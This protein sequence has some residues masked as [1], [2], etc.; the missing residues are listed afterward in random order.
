MKVSRLPQNPIITP[1]MDARMGDNINGPSLIEAPAWLPNRLGRYYLYFGHH[2]G[3]YIR[4]AVADDIAGPWR[5]HEPGVLPLANSG[6]AGHIASPDVHVDE[7]NQQI[8][9][10]YHGCDLPTGQQG[11]QPTRVALSSDGLHFEA[12]AENLGGSYFRVFQHENWHYALVMPGQFLRSRD[13]LTEFEPGPVVFAASMRHSA[14][15]IRT[16]QLT[17]VYSIV[18]DAPEH[19]VVSIVDLCSDWHHWTATP[20]KTVLRT[21]HHFEGADL[22]VAPSIRGLARERKHELRD[23]ALFATP[24]TDYLLYSVA[25]EHGIAIAKINEWSD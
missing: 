19:L 16:S 11:E 15:Q 12:R 7:A 13:G 8:R 24:D 25:G 18:G 14:V 9:M 5:M 6:F 10:Y 3:R 4:L 20:P 23:P 21:E 17:V 22:P 2:D 1:H